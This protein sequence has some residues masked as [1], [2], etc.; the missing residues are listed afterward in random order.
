MKKEFYKFLKNHGAYR[1]WHAN[2]N[3][4][5]DN[6]KISADDFLNI[7]DPYKYISSAFWWYETKDTNFWVKLDNEWEK[8]INFKT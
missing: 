1:K 5:P 3:A 7:I 4:D 2:F 8:H 6:N